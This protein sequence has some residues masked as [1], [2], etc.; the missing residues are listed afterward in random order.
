MTTICVTTTEIAWDSQVT[1]GNERSTSPI[2]KVRLVRPG[3][4]FAFSGDCNDEPVLEE[5]LRVHGMN[6]KRYPKFREKAE[7]TAVVVTRKG[8]FE[9]DERGAGHGIQISPPI[10]I[11]SGADYARSIIAANKILSTNFTA[12]DA[13][14]VAA[15][16]DVNTGPPFKTLNIRKALYARKKP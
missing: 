3:I 6:P 14:K 10:C 4:I 8:F 16:C 12:L 1:I 11:G 5:W 2:E 7:F 15:E 13:V 9:F